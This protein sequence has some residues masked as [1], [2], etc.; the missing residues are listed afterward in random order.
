MARKFIYN[1]EKLRFDEVK[2][3][4]RRIVVRV[5][6]YGVASLAIAALYYLVFA[7]I[8]S[9]DRE[10]RLAAENAYLQKELSQ[11]EEKADLVG[12]VVKNLQIR[13]REI[14]REIFNSEPPALSMIEERDSTESLD[15]IYEESEENL[16]WDC[17]VKVIELET[18]VSRINSQIKNISDLIATEGFDPE[19]IP[20]IIPLRNFTLAQVG[21]STGQKVNPFYKTIREHNGID[22][23]APVGTDVL[24]TASGVVE[25]VERGKK[26]LGNVVK[27]AHADGISTLYAHLSDIYVS[28]G[29]AVERGNVIART[30]NSGTVFAPTLH[31]EVRRDTTVLEPVNYFFADLS[32]LTF[33]EMMVISNNSGQSMD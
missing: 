3:S 2:V 20:S 12:D 22:L 8:F 25:A 23:M 21:A 31:Y 5:L 16:V 9:T 1:K 17:H 27:I 4:V 29:Q 6:Q 18:V 19:A 7:T 14:Y 10:K 11:M 33:R 30:G 26:G 32:P 13:D 15:Y 28:K 24:A